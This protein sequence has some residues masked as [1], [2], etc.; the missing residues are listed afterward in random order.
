[1]QIAFTHFVDLSFLCTN[2]EF[3]ILISKAFHDSI[4]HAYFDMKV[5]ILK[6]K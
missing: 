1:L 4:K 6:S 3:S 5:Y 2:V